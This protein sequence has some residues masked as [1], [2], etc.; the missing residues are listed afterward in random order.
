MPQ[1]MASRLT[2]SGRQ[3]ESKDKKTL[4]STLIQKSQTVTPISH[5]CLKVV[6]APRG[7]IKRP[8]LTINKN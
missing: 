5:F 2:Y 4:P 6:Q 1:N 8:T 7:V 3:L